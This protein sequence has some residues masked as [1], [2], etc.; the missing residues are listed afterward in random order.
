[1]KKLDYINITSVAEEWHV[2]GNVSSANKTGL[3]ALYIT[4]DFSL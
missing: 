4:L 3:V 1:M 2:F